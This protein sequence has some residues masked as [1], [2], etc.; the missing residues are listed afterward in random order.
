MGPAF[1]DKAYAMMEPA[2]QAQNYLLEN[3][4]KVLDELNAKAV[5]YEEITDGVGI[6]GSMGKIKGFRRM[7]EKT[8]TDNKGDLEEMKDI[9]RA[10]IAVDMPAEVDIVAQAV[11]RRFGLMRDKNRFKNPVAGY[12]DLLLNF[13]TPQGVIGEIQVHLKPILRA[14]ETAGHK[15]LERHRGMVD[16]TS[17]VLVAARA[18]LEKQMRDLY[19]GAW[20]EALGRAA[21]ITAARLAAGGRF[22]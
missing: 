3:L 7:L 4:A 18:A 8:I 13:R 6:R 9:V 14:K 10:T 12:R 16:S 15:L 19:E 5:R 17:Q 21:V 1:R 20:K 11:Q 22:L 2:P